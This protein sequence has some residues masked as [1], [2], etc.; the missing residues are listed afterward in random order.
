VAKEVLEAQE[1]KKDI[2]IIMDFM[3]GLFALVGFIF[4]LL[5][6][7]LIILQFPKNPAASVIV[8]LLLFLMRA[9][10][11]KGNSIWL[12]FALFLILIWS[13]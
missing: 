3:V 11:F 13:F 9:K 8:L 7:V 5:I 4:Y 10:Y 1:N 2:I 6:L 12:A